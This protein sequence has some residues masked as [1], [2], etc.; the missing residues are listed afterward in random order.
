M[1]ISPAGG[2]P[3]PSQ[4]YE[5]LFGGTALRNAGKIELPGFREL[6]DATMSAPDQAARKLAFANLQRFV[7]ENALQFVQYVAPGVVIQSK[8]LQ[9][10]Q[11]NLLTTP[12][13][14]EVWLS[15]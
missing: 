11:D 9:N 12:K 15:A 7:V 10:F 3:D 13:L 5:A 1:H 14:H 8:K 4:A 2:F 6:M